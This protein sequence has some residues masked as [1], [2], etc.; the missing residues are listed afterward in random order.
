MIALISDP[1]LGPFLVVSIALVLVG[2]A[3][4]LDNYF[5]ARHRK[6]LR[7]A[8]FR[9]DLES[10]WVQLRATRPCDVCRKH[11]TT[12]YFDGFMCTDLCVTCAAEALQ[13]GERA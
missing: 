6:Q 1:H 10:Q 3:F 7:E 9:R 8:Y 11:P 5:E 13:A 12:L 4:A 2:I